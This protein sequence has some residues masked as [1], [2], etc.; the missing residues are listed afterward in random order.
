MSIKTWLKVLFA[1]ASILHVLLSIA[2]GVVWYTQDRDNQVSS[3]I[4][5]F[6][7]PKLAGERISSMDVTDFNSIDNFKKN[8]TSS[9]SHDIQKAYEKV[10]IPKKDTNRDTFLMLTVSVQGEMTDLRNYTQTWMSIK[11][12]FLGVS[13]INGYRLLIGM[14]VISF[15]F[16]FIFC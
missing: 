7:R 14:F 11:Y 16:Q 6:Y 3:Y 9:F 12:P 4:Y 13:E 5:S 15:L 8:T 1:S 2:S 10:C